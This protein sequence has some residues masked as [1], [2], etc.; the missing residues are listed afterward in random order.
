MALHGRLATPFKKTV[1]LGETNRLRLFADVFKLTNQY[2]AEIITVATGPA[3]Q[4]PTANRSL[5]TCKSMETSR[6]L[7]PKD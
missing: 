4:N 3:F 1:R 7:F 2:A 5:L 6:I